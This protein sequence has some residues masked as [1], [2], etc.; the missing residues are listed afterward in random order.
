MVATI[1]ER[2]MEEGVSRR[3]SRPAYRLA[4]RSVEEGSTALDSW[5][6]M[7]VSLGVLALAAVALF[8][9]VA[10]LSAL[11]RRAEEQRERLPEGALGPGAL[12]DALL[13]ALATDHGRLRPDARIE[14]P[15]GF[16]TVVARRGPAGF[17]ALLPAL[18]FG[19][20]QDL[21]LVRQTA[22]ALRARHG[23]TATLVIVGGG[24]RFGREALREVTGVRGV[25]VS[26]RGG[27]TEAS[28][29]GDSIPALLVRG[30]VE[31]TAR[32]FRRGE[33]CFVDPFAARKLEA[34][35]P[36]QPEIRPPA[37]G[38]VTRSLTATVVLVFAVQAWFLGGTLG[39]DGRL[40]PVV[41]RLG[42]LA[43]EATLGGEWQR[44]L[45]APFLHYGVLHLAMNTWAQW[46]LGAPL[47]YLLGS[48]R[49]LLLWLLSAVG[50]GF[51]SLAWN[52]GA[53][54][55]GASGAVFGLLGALSGFVFFRRDVLPQPVPRQLK[56][57]VIATLLLN[58]L[59][60]LVPNIDIAAHVGGA[61]VGLVGS[62][63]PNLLTR[64][65]ARPS[66]RL[67]LVPPL[68]ALVAIGSIAARRNP[69][70]AEETPPGAL[71]N[72]TLG[73][74]PIVWPEGFSWS[75]EALSGW[76]V[77]TGDDSPAS[78]YRL[79]IRVSDPWPTDQMLRTALEARRDEL[80]AAGRGGTANAAGAT[81][82]ASDENPEE[83]AASYLVTWSGTLSDRRIIEVSVETPGRTRDRASAWAR[84]IL[85]EAQARGSRPEGSPQAPR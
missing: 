51:S 16:A 53:V 56:S 31:R 5:A 82:E 42:G 44:L 52:D 80:G 49:L 43:R 74:T 55:A 26:D 67:A 84:R 75:E 62:L 39:D 70:A 78:P 57:G 61:L 2:R 40:V 30:A 69:A 36:E 24:P 15:L 22:E 1:F 8:A 85:D 32:D 35:R 48:R 19:R 66:L 34:E 72:R 7:P 21:G 28:F 12:R 68:V 4:D 20:S 17:L 11:R 81:A 77:A 63:L 14:A 71:V 47:E 58:G 65:E 45:A 37:S 64:R 73:A 79:E 76:S 13:Y 27:V 23:R 46:S 6:L 25:H 41:F 29:I 33:V 18:A 83:P 38:P 60:S 10:F 54:S 9:T 50:A 3:A 59:I